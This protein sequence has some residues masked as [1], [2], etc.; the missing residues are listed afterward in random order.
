MAT[1]VLPLLLVLMGLVSEPGLK[2]METS[3]VSS[4]NSNSKAP[5][6]HTI[7]CGPGIALVVDTTMVIPEILIKFHVIS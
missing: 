2:S 7:L 6:S 3:I 5:I 1:G 4:T